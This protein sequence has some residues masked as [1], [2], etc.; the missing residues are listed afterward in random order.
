LVTNKHWKRRC[1]VDLA[2]DLDVLLAK[3]CVGLGFCNQ[4]RGADLLRGRDVLTANEF[5]CAVLKAEG[6]DA[7]YES[8][9]RRDIARRFL[10]RYGPG[11][12]PVS[13]T[14]DTIRRFT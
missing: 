4:L 5:A 2:D 14:P 6:M 8:K 3:L 7:E 10:E 12:S 9:F 11:A 13:W 1:G